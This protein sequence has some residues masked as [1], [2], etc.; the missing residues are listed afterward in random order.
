[1]PGL[2]LGR[3]LGSPHPGSPSHSWQHSPAAAAAQGLSRDCPQAGAPLPHFALLSEGS[4]PG[5]HAW[6]SCRNEHR[7]VGCHQ[8]A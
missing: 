2:D 3:G 1:M 5:T 6:W 4:K 8:A 7:S